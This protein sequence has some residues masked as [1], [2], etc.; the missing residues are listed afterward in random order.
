MEGHVLEIDH[1]VQEHH[2]CGDCEPM[3]KRNC[4]QQPPAI[5]LAG[6]RNRDRNARSGNP[7]HCNVDCQEGDV[8][9]PALVAVK[10]R[11]AAGS[12]Y[13]PQGHRRENRKEG[14]KP[15]QRFVD[16]DEVHGEYQ[17]GA[18]GTGEL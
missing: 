5:G 13:L 2:G 3:G 17:A 15:Q 1:H 10:L 6:Y 16:G 8:M 14:P 7:D 4:V 18:G 11:T 12:Q 9:R